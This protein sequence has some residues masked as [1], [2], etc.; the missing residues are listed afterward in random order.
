M[1]TAD[2]SGESSEDMMRRELLRLLSMISVLLT[3]PNVNEQLEQLDYL[4][5]AS[6]QFDNLTIDDYA[7]LNEHLWRVFVLSKSK[8][9]VLPLVRDQFE[10]LIFCLS[11][12]PGISAHRRLCALVSELLQ[13]AGEIFF[14]ANKYSDAAYFYTLAATAS[15]E[16]RAFD[17][18]ACAMTRH[19]FIEMH[20][21]RFDKA[22]PMLELAARL[23]QRG[24][25]TLST[26]YWVSSVQ[27]QAFAGLGE[28]ASC[29]RALDI[30]QQVRELSDDAS[31][32]GWLRF[33]GS[34]L[35]EERGAGYVQLRL[36]DL[37][38]N[39]LGDAL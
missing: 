10:A 22:A 26:R 3:M 5:T 28:L 17:L 24:D 21:Q 30:A 34:R 31:N 27:A 16:A 39:A 19:A 9:A 15:K 4:S 11:R 23:A 20:E 25:G 36:P 29:Q 35:A 7:A 38:E 13:L 37:A 2:A 33:D 1:L 12:S 8:G 18:W 14:D 6:N 32:G